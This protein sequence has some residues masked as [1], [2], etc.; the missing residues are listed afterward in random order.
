MHDLPAEAEALAAMIRRRDVSA[1]EV[2]R[3][4]LDVIRARNPE[5]VAFVEVAETRALRDAQRADATAE[6]ALAPAPAF[7]GVPTG[8]K[9]NDHLRGHFT[10]VGSRALRWVYSPVDGMVARALRI[11]GFTLIGKLATSELTILPVV[12]TELGPPTRNPRAPD[13]YAGGS[14]GGSAAAVASGMLPIAPGSDGGGSIRIPAAFCGLVGFKSSRSAVPNP[15]G[16]F[17]SVGLSSLGPIAHSV[18]EAALLLDVLCGRAHVPRAPSPTSFLAACRPPPL[19]LLIRLARTTPLADVHPDIDA[20]VV[21]AARLLA[22]HGH[23]VDDAPPLVGDTDDFIPIM[24]Q[25]IASV[26]LLPGSGKQLQPSTRW[27]RR[28]GRDVTRRQ[29]AAAAHELGRRVIEWCGDADILITPTVPQP[30]PRVG[31]FASIHDDGEAVFRAMAPIGAFTA[32]FNVSGQPA[33]SLPAGTTRDGLPI[34]VQIVGRRGA[35]RVVLAVATL[36]EAELRR[37]AGAG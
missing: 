5:L 27:L 32:P 26:P 3:H 18:R 8:I 14:S 2:T 17:D 35:D 10:R 24:A 34:G 37:G 30:A 22:D 9:D 6:R 11:A 1:V 21:R 31:A 4:Y 19:P 12:D 36:L 7:L 28:R 23:H 29:A 13:H 15:Y 25:M 33:I 16:M 20:A